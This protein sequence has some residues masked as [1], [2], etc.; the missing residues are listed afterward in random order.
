MLLSYP[1]YMAFVLYFQ[2]PWRW[3][4][5]ARLADQKDQS[6]ALLYLAPPLQAD[7]VRNC[8]V[9]ANRYDMLASFDKNRR[10][11]EVGTFEGKFAREIL[12]R[13]QPSELH[14]IDISMALARDQGHISEG[15]GVQFHEGDSAG[16]LASFPDNH[17]DYIYVDARHDLFGVARDVDQAVKKLKQDGTLVFNDYILLSHVELSVFGIVPVVNSLCNDDGWE[18]TALAMH[19]KM[20]CDVALR[21]RGQ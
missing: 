10:W 11:A 12:D 13:C 19:Y 21:R 1:A 9:F 20:Y 15:N 16:V 7:H 3:L 18:M 17:F 2:K 14:V 8:R 5:G 4:F 6:G